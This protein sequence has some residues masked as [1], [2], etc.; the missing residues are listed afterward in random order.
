MAAADPVTPPP[1]ARRREPFPRPWTDADLLAARRLGVF[2]GR[3]LS[4]EGGRLVD[5]AGDPVRLTGPEYQALWG[6]VF[7]QEQRVQ[8]IRGV[9]VMESP[10]NPPHG[11]ALR[12][13]TKR[14]ERVFAAGYDVRPQMPLDLGLLNRPEP[15][16]A[17]VVGSGE[18][19][20]GDDHPTTAVLVV[21]VADSSLFED[22][23]TAAELYAE[24]GIADYWVL[25]VSGRE[26]HV[27]RDP[28][29]VAAGGHAYRTHLTLGPAD[30]VTPLAAPAAS[31]LVSD[32]LP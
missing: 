3:E 11:K 9:V 25:D 16:V 5:T 6:V 17:V 32:L 20:F 12:R 21:E 8:L 19:D 2:A 31:I 29:P 27:L 18:D 14:L 4:V 26:L 28:A 22:L 23:T 30:A 24:G 7:K 15:D 13:T 1:A 10:M